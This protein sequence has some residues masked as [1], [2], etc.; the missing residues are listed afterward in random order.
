MM[1]IFFNK[2]IKPVSEGCGSKKESCNKEGCGSK[3]EGCNKEDCGSKKQKVTEACKSKKENCSTQDEFSVDRIKN[4]FEKKKN[5]I[6]KKFKAKKD[7][8][9]A[10]VSECI[11]KIFNDAL[12]LQLESGQ[13][14]EAMKRNL[15]ESFVEEKGADNLLENMKYIS[16]PMANMALLCEEYLEKIFEEVEED[17]TEFIINN[18]ERD[19]FYNKIKSVSTDDISDLVKVRVMAAIQ[20]FTQSNRN[21]KSDIENTLKTTQSHI[22]NVD[23]EGVKES[24][25]LQAKR[26]NTL[27]EYNRT[28]NI[29][30]SMIENISKST[31]NNDSMKCYTEAETGRL[32]MH[33]IVE[34]TRVM[35]TFMEVLNTAKLE[36]IT[37]SYI[38]DA[39]SSLK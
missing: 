24:F 16:A 36:N 6:A 32:D 5:K 29:F 27:A 26:K 38:R 34:N 30:E 7:T 2:K 13:S 18:K 14:Y 8:K 3:K 35:Y 22:D 23:S 39:L 31:L 28:K 33:K 1:D 25:E 4:K 19:S 17:E 37:E 10:L 11:Y 20:D 15:V 12:G 9:K 21:I